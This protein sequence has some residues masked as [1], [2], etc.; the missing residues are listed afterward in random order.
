MIRSLRRL[1]FEICPF[2]TNRFYSKN[3]NLTFY[4]V[5]ENQKPCQSIRDREEMWLKQESLIFFLKFKYNVIKDKN[6]D[7]N[8]SI[9]GY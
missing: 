4:G 7:L 1:V 2:P 3:Q 8:V 5:D 9:W 6:V